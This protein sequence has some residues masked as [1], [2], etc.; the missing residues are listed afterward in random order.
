MNVENPIQSDLRRILLGIPGIPDVKWEGKRYEPS[1]GVAYLMERMDPVAS[2]TETLG[3]RGKTQDNYLYRLTLYWP[4]EKS[5]FEGRSITAAIRAAFYAGRE[6]A[7]VIPE[8]GAQM[9]GTVRSCETRPP[10][11]GS[12]F[13]LL[14]IVVDFYI[15]RPTRG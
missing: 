3:A 11:E 5:L 1:S 6:V 8:T 7:G 14:P 15:R 2:R 10:V 13:T 4:M 12:V 9:S